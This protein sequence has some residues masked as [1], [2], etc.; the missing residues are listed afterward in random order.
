MKVFNLVLLLV[1]VAGVGSIVSITAFIP[2][3]RAGIE[4]QK[5]RLK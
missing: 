1:V 4:L 2:I 5:V 3:G